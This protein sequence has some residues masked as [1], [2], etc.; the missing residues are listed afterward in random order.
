MLHLATE[1]SVYYENEIG[2]SKEVINIRWTTMFLGTAT[3]KA[4]IRMVRWVTN[5]YHLYSVNLITEEI[6]NQ[7]I[8]F[9]LNY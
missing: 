7:K 4:E 8:S 1:C 2:I 6:K 9:R 3:C 5:N